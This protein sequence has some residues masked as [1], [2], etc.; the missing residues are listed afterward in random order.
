MQSLCDACVT[1]QVCT[2]PT[3]T[4]KVLQSSLC[5]RALVSHKKNPKHMAYVVQCNLTEDH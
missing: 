5:L 4:Q 2:Y 3:N 1:T